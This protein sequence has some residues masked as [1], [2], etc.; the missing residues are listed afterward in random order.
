MRVDLMDFCEQCY[1]QGI[2]LSQ[3]ELCKIIKTNRYTVSMAMNDNDGI[4]DIPPDKG[5]RLWLFNPKAIE[6]P[7]DFFY[8]TT[9]SFLAT[10]AIEGRKMT[11]ISK[12]VE[13][14]STTISNIIKSGNYFLYDH[15][16]IFGAFESI[17]IPKYKNEN[18]YAFLNNS[19]FE[20]KLIAYISKGTIPKAVD[21]N[22][23]IVTMAAHRM[24]PSKLNSLRR[25][26]IK[27]ITEHLGRLD[28]KTQD[29]ILMHG[30]TKRC[31]VE[32]IGNK[33]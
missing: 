30:F 16:D 32:Q 12:T 29:A 22:E 31:K 3:K 18:I 11:E 28:Q 9:A 17:Y 24:D 8:Y 10:K 21:K 15:K 5:V 1:Q 4:Y 7:S 27:T 19:K 13:K 23:F 14:P 6:L 25:K 2:K 20:E 33:A 26:Y